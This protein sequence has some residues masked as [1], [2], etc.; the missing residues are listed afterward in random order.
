[1]IRDAELSDVVEYLAERGLIIPEDLK[2]SAVIIGESMLLGYKEVGPLIC[3]VHICVRKSAVRR[4]QEL[5]EI[6]EYFLRLKGFQAMITAIHPDYKT[7]TKFVERIGFK[8]I[9]CYN[10]EILFCKGL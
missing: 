8:R 7:A 6:G 9:G 10:E 5:T 4:A 3:E 1:M 2:E